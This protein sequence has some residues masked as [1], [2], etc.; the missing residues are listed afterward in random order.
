MN[1]TTTQF[2]YKAN[3]LTIMTND[4]EYH[5]D[6]LVKSNINEFL[7]E[8]NPFDMNISKFNQI[9]IKRFD[10]RSEYDDLKLG[11]YYSY[12]DLRYEVASEY[13]LYNVIHKTK[14]Y[15]L[16]RTFR[17]TKTRIINTQSYYEKELISEV[18]WKYSKTKKKNE[19]RLYFEDDELSLRH[20]HEH[21]YK[22]LDYIMKNNICY[23]AFKL[24][25]GN[26]H[27]ININDLMRDNKQKYRDIS[28]FNRRKD[29]HD[30]RNC[31]S[32]YSGLI[33]FEG[34]NKTQNLM[35]YY[36][37]IKIMD[38]LMINND[39]KTIKFA[40]ELLSLEFNNKGGEFNR[41][42]LHYDD[43]SSLIKKYL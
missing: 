5:F 14:S 10:S 8:Y 36:E 38:M 12:N 34:R 28:V 15:C 13:T 18:K 30:F 3:D 25:C 35:N 22:D 23:Y 29:W 17:Y 2:I 43:V 24:N 31:G 26:R 4:K 6:G 41:D 21:N 27:F 42:Q 37:L 39:K 20:L 16:I 32:A 1:Y 11:K 40:K 33:I 7:G 9:H 19:K